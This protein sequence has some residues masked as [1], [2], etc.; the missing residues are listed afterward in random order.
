MFGRRAPFDAN[1]NIT[2]QFY[3]KRYKYQTKME[4]LYLQ[5]WDTKNF[6]RCCFRCIFHLT[7]KPPHTNTPIDLNIETWT[8]VWTRIREIP[9]ALLNLPW[10]AYAAISCLPSETK[11]THGWRSMHIQSAAIQR[12]GAWFDRLERGHKMPKCCGRGRRAETMVKQMILWPN[13]ALKLMCL[14]SNLFPPTP[15]LRETFG[16]E[17]GSW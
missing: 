6:L 7:N 10:K 13:R 14:I 16:P 3:F 2:Y 12:Y 8:A 15:F 1:K 5:F 11:S 4:G 17:R 9:S